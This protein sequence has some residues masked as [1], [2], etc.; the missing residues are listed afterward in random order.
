MLDDEHIIVL[1]LLLVCLLL[2]L[3][4]FQFRGV[5]TDHPVDTRGLYVRLNLHLR[6]CEEGIADQSVAHVFE[7]QRE[8]FPTVLARFDEGF[9]TLLVE[10]A[11]ELLDFRIFVAEYS[12]QVSEACSQP[13]RV[14]HFFAHQVLHHLLCRE[15]FCKWSRDTILE[16]DALFYPAFRE[17]VPVQH[18]ADLIQFK[19]R[20]KLALIERHDFVN[21]GA[22][23]GVVRLGSRGRRIGRSWG[24]NH[25]FPTV[26]R[27]GW[28]IG[29]TC[30]RG[31]RVLL[32]LLVRSCELKTKIRSPHDH[33]SQT[34]CGQPSDACCGVLLLVMKLVHQQDSDCD[35]RQ[36]HRE[37]F[38]KSM[39]PL[40]FS[41]R[42]QRFL[43]ECEVNGDCND[44]INHENR[45]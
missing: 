37:P 3:N 31:L 18:T 1:R 25:Q 35:N 10:L 44:T 19:S 34:Y 36:S 33:Q 17:T 5:G 42:G 24:V 4:I 38:S 32:I 39:V 22:V 27:W 14:A 2:D 43:G 28:R 13:D 12:F 20:E 21:L 15:A 45:D 26:R 6:D 9:N 40:E 8:C 7:C 30:L 16:K 41:L 11:I 29:R 23:R